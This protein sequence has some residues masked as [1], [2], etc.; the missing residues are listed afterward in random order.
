MPSPN[1]ISISGPTASG[2]T[3]LAIQLAQE[4]KAEIISFDSRQIYNEL[5]IGV[6]RPSEEELAKV[7]H[8]LIGHKSIHEKY[9]AQD[10]VKEVESIKSKVKSQKPL[11]LVGGT[12]FFLFALENGLDELPDISE[13]TRNKVQ[14]EFDRYGLV[15]MQERV[16]EID[17][18]SYSQ[19]EI[20]NPRRLQR[21]VEIW[22]ETGDVYSELVSRDSRLHGND[23]E[24]LS[25]LEIKNI[26]LDIP[27]EILYERINRRVDE[28]IKYGLVEEAKHYFPDRNLNA[29]N[30]VGYKELFAY[31]DGEMSLEEAI[32][33][34]KQHTRNYAKRQITWNKKYLAYALWVNPLSEKTFQTIVDYVH[35]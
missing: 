23:G 5:N 18:V 8:H 27:R 2:K 35:S 14:Q 9:S 28:M 21:I 6:A 3:K 32:D 30:T 29:L 16:K 4:L 33:K 19:M 10:F 12:G 22:E 31:F 25:Q 15:Y 11:I 13:D 17:P 1:L 26:V 20:T 34:I 7:K 24:K